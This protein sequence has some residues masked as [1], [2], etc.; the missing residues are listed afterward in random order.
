[1]KARILLF[2][3]NYY[4]EQ[5]GIGKYT[6]EFAEYLQDKGHQISVITTPP[7]YPH[8]K[9]QEP[10]KS[11]TWKR[12]VIN[13]VK[14]LRTPLYVPG[15]VSGLSRIIHELS[16]VLGSLP[17]FFN[18]LFT[19]V[20]LILCVYPPL[21]MTPIPLFLGW[22]RRKPVL[23]HIQDLQVD[24]ARDLGIIKSSLLL[25]LLERIERSMFKRASAVSTISGG[26]AK[27]LKKKGIPNP[28]IFFNWV[29]TGKVFPLTQSVS[30]LR[31]SLN[32]DP[33][34]KIILYAGNLG[35]KQG[36]QILPEVARYFA[37]A[38]PG[39]HFLIVGEGMMKK[40]LV[41]H[42]KELENI[43]LRLPVPFHLLNELLN[44]A[45]FHLVMQKSG[46]SD[47]VMPSKLGPILAV[48]G[49][50]LI[51]CDSGSFL[52]SEAKKHEFGLVFEADNADKMI[53]VIERNQDH[54][55]S[56][57]QKNAISYAHQY[58][59][60]NRVLSEFEKYL[61]GNL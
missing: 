60:R 15:K 39:I 26:M 21:I 46:S 5:T 29:D 49:V 1:M 36:L 43:E 41:K 4:P 33:K 42:T 37:K 6:T 53:Q 14:V 28:I 17:Y 40:W 11:F 59:D 47:L 10:Y 24:A 57:L 56:E 19:K 51:G 2:S 34:K 25:K 30:E 54:D 3:V 45:D 31:T 12:E 9:V 13:G 16:F 44:V 7:Y 8:W 35:E 20:D 58:L 27:R 32:L 18:R 52:E 61:L 22:L 50:P 55:L 38:D 23:Y 48:G